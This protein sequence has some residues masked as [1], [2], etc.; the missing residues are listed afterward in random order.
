MKH[1]D[2]DKE[3]TELYQQRKQQVVAPEI[4]LSP[5]PKGKQSRYSLM[6]L[7]SILFLGGASSFGIL[8]MISHF[9]NQPVKQ[10]ISAP[11]T[12]VNIVELET[13]KATPDDKVIAAIK[14]PL[15]PKKP[16]VPPISTKNESA[17]MV[18]NV[19][20]ELTFTL[21]IDVVSV[22]TSPTVKQPELSLL[23]I[24]QEQ[25]KYPLK[26]IRAK[27]SGTVKLA[28]SISAQGIVE[29]IN[30]IESNTSRELNHAARKALSKWRYRAGAYNEEGYEIT[31]DF[32]L[33][34]K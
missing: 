19:P 17:L 11:A 29:D 28:Y 4:D 9:A 7:L 8:A 2:S 30:T 26:A 31:F 18:H 13:D 25:P 23:P 12:Q 22:S 21:P 6:Q 27:H 34:K 14:A 33:D 3:I 24:Y 15:V 5:L 32:T 20:N 16:Y 1:Q 10:P